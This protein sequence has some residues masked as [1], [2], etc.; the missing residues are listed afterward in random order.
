MKDGGKETKTYGKRDAKEGVK[1]FLKL[2]IINLVKH[3]LE[4]RNSLLL[5]N[6]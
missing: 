5:K 1:L 6:N 3:T 4:S 2:F